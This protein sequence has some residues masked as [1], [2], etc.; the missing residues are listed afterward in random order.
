VLD[1]VLVVVELEVVVLVVDDVVVV[2]C[3]QYRK[4]DSGLKMK[5]SRAML[6]A[7]TWSSHVCLFRYSTRS[8]LLEHSAPPKAGR[9]GTDPCSIDVYLLTIEF[10]RSA[11]GLNPFSTLGPTWHPFRYLHSSLEQVAASSATTPVVCRQP[12]TSVVK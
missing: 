11:N 2:L 9:G 7:T 4:T 3:T 10:R 5:A 12:M 8:W 6:M 1:D